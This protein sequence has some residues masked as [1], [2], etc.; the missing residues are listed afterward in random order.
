MFSHFS[1]WKKSKIRTSS[2]VLQSYDVEDSKTLC[3]SV[4]DVHT[5]AIF[6]LMSTIVSVGL[7]VV[8][9]KSHIS[10]SFFLTTVALITV[11]QLQLLSVSCSYCQST[12]H[13]RQAVLARVPTI[14]CLNTTTSEKMFSQLVNEGNNHVMMCFFIITIMAAS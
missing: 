10:L 7:C 13:T 5:H 9:Q 3:W 1:S 6:N 4:C 8:L 2:F 11:C 12:T 14:R